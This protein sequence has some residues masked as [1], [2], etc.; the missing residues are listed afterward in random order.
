MPAATED[1]TKQAAEDN[2]SFKE[3]MGGFMEKVKADAPPP[4]K[5]KEKPNGKSDTAGG[6]DKQQP[7]DKLAVDAGATVKG[8]G[9]VHTD[10]PRTVDTG[11]TASDKAPEKSATKAD[12]SDDD[13]DSKPQPKSSD[14]WETFKKSRKVERDALRADIKTR[15]DKIEA[16]NK[17]QAELEAKV[18]TPARAELS[19]EIKSKIERLEGEN[20]ELHE[21]ITVLDVTKNPK[22]EKYFSEKFTEIYSDAKSVVGEEQASRIERILKFQDPEYRQE[23]L[24]AFYADMEDEGARDDLRAIV[25]DLK[26]VER[27]RDGE[28][29]KADEHRATIQAKAALEAERNTSHLKGMFEQAVKGVQDPEKGFAPFQLRDGDE[30]WNKGVQTRLD[31][32]R[33]LLFSPQEL[34]QEAAARY[35]FAAVGIAPIV[36]SYKAD[37][38]AW[39]QEKANLEAQINELK[40]AQPTAG[41][42]TSK[43]ITAGERTQMSRDMK[44]GAHSRAWANK[45]AEMA[46][47]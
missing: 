26:K 24:N 33:K 31:E 17:K 2:S 10:K 21:R 47:Q 30:N 40:G 35:A 39:A 27:E 46:N 19:D 9:D 41:T 18:Q 28:V 38:S 32:V 23:Q 34:S 25:R 14:Q 16:L 15:E 29:K 22:F 43:T 37:K 5:S 45:A 7:A 36:E 1:T 12:P 6:S 42:T 8:A 20:K 4:T 11:K 3:I 13:W 44:P